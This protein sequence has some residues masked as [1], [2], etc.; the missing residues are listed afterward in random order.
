MRGL[1]EL[2]VSVS[3]DDLL[4][5]LKNFDYVAAK[6]LKRGT[7]TTTHATA[8][9]PSQFKSRIL[10]MMG[11]LRKH[12]ADKKPKG[13]EVSKRQE[14]QQNKKE[15]KELEAIR[16]DLKDI[17]TLYAQI[18]DA[19]K[20][21]RIHSAQ[22]DYRKLEKMYEKLDNTSRQQHY[23]LVQDVYKKIVAQSHVEK[24]ELAEVTAIMDL[25]N[26]TEKLIHK[27]DVQESK[28][29]YSTILKRYQNLESKRQQEI[30]DRVNKLWTTIKAKEA[31]ADI[32]K[33]E[34]L[35]E[36]A[37][38]S[39]NNND[40]E[41]ASK[42]YLESFE[43]YKKLPHEHQNRLYTSLKRFYDETHKTQMAVQ[44]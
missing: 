11:I 12:E 25:L 24:T 6:L 1:G 36:K 7:T 40:A 30:Y 2:Q 32:K 27:I 8:Q 17:K 4:E 42:F 16:T 19:L 3:K 10:S 14:K 20:K 26:E 13:K 28:K 21:N 5:K 34:R 9:K 35:L 41:S 33:I 18:I 38:Q 31:D 29:K 43:L 22:K 44:P 37:T 23:N 15:I 39:L